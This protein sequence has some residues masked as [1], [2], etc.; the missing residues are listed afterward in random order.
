MA[1][2]E[3]LLDLC[4]D[5][6]LE[7]CE[8]H[9]ANDFYGHAAALKRYAGLDPDRPLNAVVE[10][11]PFNRD[12]VWRHDKGAGF[13]DVFCF[14]P[15]RGP[16]IQSVPDRRAHPLGPYIH[17]AEPLLDP[18]GLAA[19]KK[20]LGR[21]L[22][23]FPAHSSLYVRFSYDQQDFFRR[24]EEL[25]REFDSIRV[26]LYFQDV[27]DRSVDQ[28]FERGYECV[29]AGHMFDPLFLPRLRTIIEGSSACLSNSWGTY[30]GYAVW[31]GKPFQLV[32][33][34]ITITHQSEDVRQNE[35]QRQDDPDRARIKSFFAEFTPVLSKEQIDSLRTRWGFN[36]VRE[37]DEL[38]ALIQ[39]IQARAQGRT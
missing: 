35:T 8:R 19:E 32:D 29:S 5:R 10:H 16:V 24:I 34:R 37:R 28:Y 13:A 3:D 30:L 26:C 38:R 9:K 36:H 27:L 31:M 33:S 17:Y 14:G 7:T 18:A 22:L 12:Y 20:R 25:G 11:A 1:S 15:D 39:S 6:P 21:S 2:L 4:R 23:V